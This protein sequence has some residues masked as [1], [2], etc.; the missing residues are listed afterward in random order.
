MLQGTQIQTK[1]AVDTA[2]RLLRGC[3]ARS[4]LTVTTR[5]PILRRTSCGRS[6]PKSVSIRIPLSSIQ[7][8]KVPPPWLHCRRGLGCRRQRRRVVGDLA[9]LVQHRLPPSVETTASAT[10]VPK[11]RRPPP[12]QSTRFPP[13]STLQPSPTH[14]GRLLLTPETLALKHLV[15]MFRLPRRSQRRMIRL[16]I[17]CEWQEKI[18]LRPEVLLPKGILSKRRPRSYDFLSP[19]GRMRPIFFYACVCLDGSGIGAIRSEA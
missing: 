17:L 14:S 6:K 12:S 9:E 7:R 15:T 11:A 16:L 3:S 10:S 1:E 2:N 18:P 8:A 5:G 4:T 13:R 19:H